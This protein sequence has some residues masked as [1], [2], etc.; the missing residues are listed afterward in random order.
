[1]M[2]LYP[3]GRTVTHLVLMQMERISDW[4]CMNV[5]FEDFCD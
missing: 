3:D 4:G 2:Y 5:H 1:M